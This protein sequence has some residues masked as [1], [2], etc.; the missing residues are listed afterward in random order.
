MRDQVAGQWPEE[1]EHR[2]PVVGPVR[3]GHMIMVK[4]S[5]EESWIQDSYGRIS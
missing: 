5:V 4:L 2:P 1:I 3:S